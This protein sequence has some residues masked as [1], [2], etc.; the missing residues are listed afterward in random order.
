[1]L[2]IL[3][4]DSDAASLCWLCKNLALRASGYEVIPFQNP[5]LA[6]QFISKHHNI[7][8]AMFTGAQM[9]PIDGIQLTAILHHCAPGAATYVLAQTDTRALR[10]LAKHH[11]ACGFLSKPVVSADIEQAVALLP[12]VDREKEIE[13]C[14][15]RCRAARRRRE[16]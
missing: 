5:M 11:G 4:V 2:K 8:A 1:M 15:H 6:A 16:I 9:Y 13:Q 10:A 3:A 12:Q 14:L 7:I